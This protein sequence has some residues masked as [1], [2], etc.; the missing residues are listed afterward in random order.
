[1]KWTR[2][3]NPLPSQEPV[4][5]NK[6]T[7]AN[8][9][10][11]KKEMLLKLKSF[12]QLIYTHDFVSVLQEVTSMASDRMCNHNLKVQTKLKEVVIVARLIQWWVKE[13][14]NYQSGKIRE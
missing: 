6:S 9:V 8:I 12:L 7:R 14:F 11:G 1:M 4:L 2:Q 5:F 3:R 10:Y 13:E